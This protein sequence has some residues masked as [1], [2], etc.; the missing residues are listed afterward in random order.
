MRILWLLPVLPY[1]PD[2]GGKQDSYFL[3]REFSRLGDEITCGVIYHG[4]EQP[5]IPPEFAEL[6]E[7]V[8]FLPGNPKALAARL[9]ASLG[10]DIPFKFRKYYSEKAIDL[11]VGLLET[12][13]NFDV[14]IIHHLHLVPLALDSRDRLA[15]TGNRIP[16]IILRTPNVESA[17]VDKYSKRIDNP[18]IKTFA[19][20]EAKKMKKY[21]GAVMAEFDLVAAISPV[22]RDVLLEMSKGKGRIISVTAG[23]DADEIRIS[24]NA[25]QP[26]EVAFVGTFDWHP[27]VD[28]ALWMIGKVWPSVIE[29]IPDAHLSLVGRKPPPPLS[30]AATDSVTV[31][32][33]V[34][35][36]GEYVEYASCIAVPL[37]IGSGMR[38]KILEAFAYGK[39][40]V[41]TSLGAEGIEAVDGEHI[42]LRDDP[43]EFADAVVE[44]L[45]DES[46]RDML[47]KNAR[48]L[49]EEKYTWMKVSN[50]MRNA[51]GELMD[52]R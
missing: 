51:I 1:P 19:R 4:S 42:L 23:M 41:S 49:V 46:K 45:S 44:I 8:V 3:I 22:D 20:K 9:F 5:S 2:T 47:G 17:I 26:G 10:D 18:L 27:N 29:R 38:L 7:R 14:V 35:S 30:N 39:A 43:K 37:W 12:D 13:L 15:R 32:G 48:K 16:P 36:V 24:K 50:D 25:P 52:N 21:E 28:G 34:D 6:V 31:T 40:V 11:V 33:W